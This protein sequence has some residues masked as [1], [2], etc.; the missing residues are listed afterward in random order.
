MTTIAAGISTHVRASAPGKLMIAGE[1]AVLDGAPAVMAAA[2]RR[3]IARVD[4]HAPALSPFLAAAAAQIENARGDGPAAHAALHIIVDSSALHES[5]VKLGLGSSAAATVAA[6]ACALAHELPDG[7]HLASAAHALD[8]A[9]V[10]R[11]AAAAHGDA[12]AARGARGSGA[13][14]AASTY[15]GVIELRPH[16]IRPLAWPADAVIVPFWTGSAAD[17]VALVSAVRAARAAR[18][19]AV[20]AA[21]ESIA[22]AARSL[23]TAIDDAK[24]TD[25]IDAIARAASAFEH[26]ARATG[27]ELEP[28]VVVRARDAMRARGGAVKSC[29]AGGGDVAIAVLPLGADHAGARADLR[30]AGG[31]PLG[32]AVGAPGVDIVSARE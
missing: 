24:A 8:R 31:T 17:T 29:G 4:R 13:D 1:Y 5:G 18:P 10:H 3:V 7:P 23:I 22:D 20:D 21:L 32:I 25:V 6:I 14:I 27:L 19:A 26:L 16:A 28:E 30:A 9:L 15:G 2:D 12:Q 11:L